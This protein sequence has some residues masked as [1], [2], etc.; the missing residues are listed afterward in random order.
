MLANPA[1]IGKSPEAAKRQLEKSRAIVRKQLET[2]RGGLK[3]TQEHTGKASAK[4]N[5]HMDHTEADILETAKKYGM[6]PE[7]V[8]Q[9]LGM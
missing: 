3:S 6:T 2:F 5:E 7:E 9:E 8:I 4:K 1:S